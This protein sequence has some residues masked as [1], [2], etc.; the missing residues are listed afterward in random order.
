RKE[1]RAMMRNEN[2]WTRA[3]VSWTGPVL[4]LALVG[5]TARGDL[6][7]P[8]PTAQAGEVRT[9]AP[10]THRFA[11]VN[12]GPEEVEIIEARA[13]CGCSKP[14]WA[15]RMYRRGEEGELLLEINTLGQSAGMHTWRVLVTYQSGN[16]RVER[17]LQ[18]TG[19]VITE[20]SVQP[21]SV[22]VYAD[23]AV[24]HEVLLTDLRPKP[25]DVREVRT[26]SAKLKAQAGD[27]QR[28]ALGH[29]VRK[30]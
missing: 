20:V 26:S 3:A 10:L 21:A 9:G 14:R 24:S 11:F 17:P 16:T 28:N 7:F 5:T 22:T 2:S 15:R 29:P 23:Q 6:H 25:L 4:L 8:E 1:K 30:I 27:T 18:L 12:T 13:S 19:Q